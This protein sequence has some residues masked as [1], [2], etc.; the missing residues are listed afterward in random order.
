MSSITV[1]L[2][3]L[4]FQQLCWVQQQKK[5]DPELSTSAEGVGNTGPTSLAITASC[6]SVGS[7][8]L[9]ARA[10]SAEAEG[11]RCLGPLLK[12]P[13]ASAVPTRAL[14]HDALTASAVGPVLPTPSSEV[15]N[16]GSTTSDPRHA[17]LAALCDF[18]RP[19]PLST[20]P[21]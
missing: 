7:W 15:D 16:S 6:T 10:S 14:V 19:P 21:S 8:R 11:T 20:C 18:H 12:W 4:L 17:C 3:T 13:P 1:R 5:S 2:G 9:M